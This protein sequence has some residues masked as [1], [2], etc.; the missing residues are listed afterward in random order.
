MR[1][2]RVLSPVVLL[3]AVALCCLGV[4]AVGVVPDIL[5]RYAQLAAKA[6]AGS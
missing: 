4:L 2:A 3:I 1:S 5:M 6:L